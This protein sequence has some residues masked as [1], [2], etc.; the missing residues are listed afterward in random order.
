MKKALLPQSKS[1]SNSAN[2]K[3]GDGNQ[4]E[5]L[6]KLLQQHFGHSNFR[7]RQFEAIETVLAGKDC[8]CLMPTGGGKSLC[9]QIPALAKAGIV[10][11]VSPLIAL[12]EN[13]V[14]ILKSQGIPAEYLSSTQKIATKEKIYDDIDSGKPILRLLYVTPELIATNGFMTKLKKIHSRGLLNLIAI[15]EA[16]C[17]SSWGHDFRS[18]YRKLSILR[19]CLPGVPILALTATAARKVQEDVIKSLCLH[20]PSILQTSFNRP[21]IFYEVR[22]KDILNDAYMDLLDMLKAAKQD[23]T[24]IYCL[25]RNTCDD[26]GARLL[27]DGISCRVYHAG[28]SDRIR[29]QALEDWASGKVPVVVATVAFGM[30]IDR[31]DVRIVCHFN[32]PKSMESF[33][34]ESGRAGRDQKPSRSLIYYGFDDRRSMEYILSNSQN[35]GHKDKS[36]DA[37]RKKCLGDFGQMVEYC[38]GSGCRRQKIL[39]HFGEQVSLSFCGKTCDSCK[40]P[41]RLSKE[42]DELSRLSSTHG[43]NNLPSV[44]IG[45]RP[46]TAGRG[47]EHMESEFWNHDNENSDSEDDISSSDDEASKMVEATMRDRNIG[48]ARLDEKLDRLLRAEEAFL[49]KQ[50]L[51]QEKKGPN[52]KKMVPENLRYAA[53]QRLK[54]AVQQAVQRLGEEKL[55]TQMV[56]TTLENQCYRKYGK[57]GKSFYNSQVASTVR[58][59]ANSSWADIQSRIEPDTALQENKSSSSLPLNENGPSMKINCSAIGPGTCSTDKSNKLEQVHEKQTFA[60]HKRT[61]QQ[62]NIPCLTENAAATELPPIPSFTN[63]AVKQG[64]DSN[65]KMHNANKKPQKILPKNTFSSKQNTSSKHTILQS[66]DDAV[67]KRKLPAIPTFDEFSKM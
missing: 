14:S 38:E 60:G 37:M 46:G 59:L 32:I 27:K 18:S 7:G 25:A 51:H 49:A 2:E 4:K 33:Y 30:G 39:A 3:R 42:L 41:S 17:I 47:Y 40:H 55:E 36:E 62:S 48:N 24:I 54:T 34:Q 45:S 50:G 44:I 1:S 22:Y 23:C 67:K 56:A 15:D 20:Q 6:S 26:I 10:L 29:S 66:G 52:D 53:R 12:M 8:F 16:H 21:N 35:K 5:F 57:S 11:V 64:K 58:W 9:Y 63:F 19:S 13:Q 65:I 28:L 61:S 31:K 43:K